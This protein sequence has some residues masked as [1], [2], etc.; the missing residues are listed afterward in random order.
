MGGCCLGD[1]NLG[2]VLRTQ[3]QMLF[4]TFAT[5]PTGTAQNLHFCQ[6]PRDRDAADPQATFLSLLR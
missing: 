4:P 6:V 2:T 3:M 1:W 5:Y